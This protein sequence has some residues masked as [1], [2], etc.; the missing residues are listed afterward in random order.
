MYTHTLKTHGEKDLKLYKYRL[1]KVRL[2]WPKQILSLISHFNVKSIND[3]GCNYFQL[4]KEIKV[5]KKNIIIL[6]MILSQ[7]S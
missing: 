7:N 4:Y 3:L 6:A 2:T 1:N 5:K